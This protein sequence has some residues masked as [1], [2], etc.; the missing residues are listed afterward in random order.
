MKRTLLF[1]ILTLMVYQVSSLDLGQEADID[2]DSI[3]INTPSAQK[4]LLDGYFTQPDT[5]IDGSHMLDL[6]YNFLLNSTMDN[7]QIV[8]NKYDSGFSLKHTEEDL[9]SSA[10]TVQIML[11]EIKNE[12][13]FFNRKQAIQLLNR[14]TYLEFI[15]KYSDELVAS[16]GDEDL[17]SNDLDL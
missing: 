16:L 7:I 1:S 2:L 4:I 5:V 12:S 6:M 9:L 3:D 15:Q 14:E 10:H 13:D 17:D 8:Q 11:N